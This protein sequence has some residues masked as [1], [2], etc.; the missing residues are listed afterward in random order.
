MGDVMKFKK[1][2][3]IFLSAAIV[4]SALFI[5]GSIGLAASHTDGEIADTSDLNNIQAYRK[6][7]DTFFCTE[8]SKDGTQRIWR[9]YTES[10]LVAAEQ[11]L[12]AVKNRESSVELRMASDD[13][14]FF[15]E[16]SFEKSPFGIAYYNVFSEELAS[17]YNSAVMGAYLDTVLSVS[18]YSFTDKIDDASMHPMTSAK[19]LEKCVVKEGGKTYCFYKAV[20]DLEYCTTAEQ[21]NALTNEIENIKSNWFTSSMSDYD[22]VKATYENIIKRTDYDTQ[23]Y[24]KF[25]RGEIKE[26]MNEADMTP[27]QLEIYRLFKLRH[28]AY[29]AFFGNTSQNRGIAL[30]DGYCAL[31]YRILREMGIECFVVKSDVYQTYVPDSDG[32][33]TS[34]LTNDRHAWLVVNLD[35]YQTAS[36]DEGTWF[37]LDVTMG[38]WF[39]DKSKNIL[40]YRYFLGY[41]NEDENAFF[42]TTDINYQAH[43]SSNNLKIENGSAIANDDYNFYSNSIL[44]KRSYYEGRIFEESEKKN[45]L[46]YTDTVYFVDYGSGTDPQR[47][48]YLI[49]QSPS[50]DYLAY[51]EET[52]SYSYPEITYSPVG[53]VEPSIYIGGLV[54]NAQF[55]IDYGNYSAVTDNAQITITGKGDIKA[56]SFSIKFKIVPKD[57]A[58]NDIISDSLSEM[59]YNGMQNKI[60]V[61]VFDGEIKDSTK[62]KLSENKDFTV[63]YF[64]HTTSSSDTMIPGKVTITVRGTGNY[65]GYVSRDFTIK[66]LDIAE[67]SSASDTDVS[68]TYTGSPIELDQSIISTIK[69]G[70]PNGSMDTLYL[71]TDYGVRYENNI[72]AGTASAVFYPLESSLKLCGEGFTKY[73][74][75]NQKP[76]SAVGFTFSA[77][78]KNNTLYCKVIP[79]S[80]SIIEGRDYSLSYAR[81]TNN[82][83]AVTV[84]GLG[85]YCS[86]KTNILAGT[87]QCAS[88]A[89]GDPPENG[90]NTQ[91]P[92]NSS[93]GSQTVID[94]IVHSHT[95]GAEI[96]Q[97]K[98]TPTS[99]GVIVKYCTSCGALAEKIIIP[100]VSGI[101]LSQSSYNYSG[102][103]KCPSVTV[104]DRL[105]NKLNASIKYSN[106]KSKKIGSYTV[107]VKIS[108]AYYDVSK[109]L[110]YTIG[111]KTQAKITSLSPVKKGFKIKIQKISKDCSG[112]Q[113]QYSTSKNFSKDVKAINL[114]GNSFTSKTVSKL[115]SGKK[116]YV[117]VRAYKTV[118]GKKCYGKFTKAKAVKAK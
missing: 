19:I 12:D 6:D 74:T 60:E 40:D 117:R 118:K 95:P 83:W 112:Y 86:S 45:L 103:V 102:K 94:Q 41:Y 115:K 72:N 108:T 52:R 31:A 77:S 4:I 14:S 2:I 58:T 66:K 53:K 76:V 82:D 99:D 62:G 68:K 38:S 3:S 88:F 64:N 111:P 101:K 73:F 5:S 27:E 87:A 16:S 10:Y 26:N 57:I 50:G 59:T 92:G 43:Y 46:D 106:K 93:N 109:V 114:K 61:A 25:L 81:S 44:A 65:N 107:T 32:N 116:Y 67:L 75:I 91:N 1:I 37:Y 98:A 79:E 42:K 54:E 20:L 48:E 97:K 105:G 70:D 89:L 15:R 21:E 8:N 24:H 28:T 85:N 84:S 22:I 34:E 56:Q 55:K 49:K 100:Y 11:I 110:T 104:K 29:S 13:S 47:R 113:L 18:S 9:E 69:F 90:N 96:V 17:K 78:I 33:L 80:S 63:E 39:S 7:G 51:D 35:S 71:G 30:C 36:S 23:I